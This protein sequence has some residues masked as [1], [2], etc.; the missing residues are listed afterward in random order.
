MDSQCAALRFKRSNVS[1]AWAALVVHARLKVFRRLDPAGD[2]L[3]AGQEID[4]LLLLVDGGHARDQ[5]CG[6]APLQVGD[7]VDIGGDE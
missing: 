5:P 4:E 6:V 3:L 7:R 1:D 2:A